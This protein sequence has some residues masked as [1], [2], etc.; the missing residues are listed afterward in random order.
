L[1]CRPGAHRVGSAQVPAPGGHV[2]ANP[3]G[4]TRKHRG[5]FFDDRL[6]PNL[7]RSENVLAQD[8]VTNHSRLFRRHP[9]QRWLCGCGSQWLL[10][11]DNLTRSLGA[12]Y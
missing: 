11:E 2:K 3:N 6:A 7:A 4:A 12:R 8:L 10:P 5:A 9:S 1:D